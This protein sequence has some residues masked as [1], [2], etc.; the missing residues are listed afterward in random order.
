[1]EHLTEPT[2]WAFLLQA[3]AAAAWVP[4]SYIAY[5]WVQAPLKRE[6]VKQSLSQLG[7]VQTKDLEET[8]A[9]EY[10]LKDYI[11]PLFLA[12]MLMSGTYT[13]KL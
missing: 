4:V 10:R 11:W 6:R 9:G 5:R 1:M 2:L 3:V 13:I 7:V 8:M 12:Y